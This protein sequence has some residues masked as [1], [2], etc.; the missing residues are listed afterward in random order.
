[1]CSPRRRRSALYSIALASSSFIFHPPDKLPTL[2][3]WSSSLNPTS[4]NCARMASR[5]IVCSCLS[6]GR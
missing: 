5:E 4:A 3:A 6:A 2:C 1:M